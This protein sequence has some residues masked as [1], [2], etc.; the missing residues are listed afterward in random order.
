MERI[1][2]TPY[3]AILLALLP[4]TSPSADDSL[5]RWIQASAAA[6]QA[7]HDGDAALAEREARR[8]LE[9]RPR[10]EAAA[11][12]RLALGLALEAA[13][14][15]AEA[16]PPLRA[17]TPDL[18][19]TLRPP[20][21]R[22]LAGVLERAGH[23][24]AAA[25][26]V[27]EAVRADALLGSRWSSPGAAGDAL[28]EGRALLAAGLPSLGAEALEAPAA[29]GDPRARLALGRARAATGDRRGD[30]LLRDVWVDRA[31]EPVAEEAGRA[32]E[33]RRADGLPPAPAGDRLA[34][35]E[36]LIATARPRLAIA[37]LEAAEAIEPPSARA[38][39]LRAMAAL[40][41]GRFADAESIAEAVA[42][43]VAGAPGPRTPARRD[44]EG[45]AEL[46]RARAAARLGRLDE[47]AGRYRRVARLRP[48]VPGLSPAVQAELPAEAAYLSA[49]LLYDAGR[50]V[51]G[52][53]A[54]ERFARDHPQAR[55]APDARWFRAWALRRAGR[56]AEARTALASLAASETG[57]LRAAA[58]YWQARLSA[59]RERAAALD[60]AALAED[61]DGWYGLLAAA[62]L[63]AAGSPASRQAL[64]VGLPPTPPGGADAAAL[65]RASDLL[66]AGLRAEGLAVLDQASRGPGARGR[67]AA[68]AELA[69]F[70]GE[71][72]IPFRLARDTSRSPGAPSAGHSRSP[73]R[74][75]SSRS[76]ARCGWTP[77]SPSP[78]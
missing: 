61:A 11:R 15:D 20:A 9:A 7:L 37:E 65:A 51:E 59:S 31:G 33:A 26:A 32:L 71:V 29:A 36:R 63:A 30:R 60:R 74:R 72:R 70:A 23:P 21:L 41:L 66:G 28:A 73:S 57:P 43:D 13:G 67:A 49:W 40:Q 46:V 52:A 54:L 16:W 14:R 58:L 25:A 62:R 44:E 3:K 50:F 48:A 78:S 69:D 64:P 17:A 19:A 68:V 8:A 18:P 2:R 75:P 5:S 4:A 1:L 56:E 42:R 53:A 55:R 27:A 22:H 10:G 34:R 39:L 45:A 76:R 24:G 77:R 6:A 38:R 35:A 47:A 12:A